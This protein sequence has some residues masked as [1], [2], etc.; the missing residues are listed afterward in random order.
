MIRNTLVAVVLFTTSPAL[1]AAEST[2][3]AKKGRATWAAFECSS[4]ASV[5]E[6]PKDQERLFRFGYEQGKEFLHALQGGRITA[7]D[8][9]SIAPSGLLMVAQGPTADFILGRVFES[10]QENALKDVITTESVL[11]KDLQEAIASRKFTS[12]N[13][14]II[15]NGR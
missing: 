12:G 2:D 7:E 8:L 10:A 6:R 11:H 13:C 5:L 4:L 1:I 15:G 3:F 14:E 9:K